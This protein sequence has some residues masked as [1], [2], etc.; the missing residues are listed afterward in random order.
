MITY[1]IN[2]MD[3]LYVLFDN[4]KS[5][6]EIEVKWY[7]E[8]VKKVSERYNRVIKSK[9]SM[10]VYSKENICLMEKYFACEKELP[11]EKIND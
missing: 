11:Y 9:I 3:L 6:N 5:Q 7:L 2:I 10:G 1:F 8:I 4:S